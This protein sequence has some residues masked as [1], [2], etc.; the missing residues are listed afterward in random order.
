MGPGF[1]SRGQRLRV[2]RFVLLALLLVGLFVLHGHGRG[3]ET[4]RIV[5]YVG[6][7]GLLFARRAGQSRR[8]GPQGGG[9]G[10]PGGYNQGGYNQGGY[11][12][13]GYNQ[14]GYNQGGYNQ[15]GAVPAAPPVRDDRWPPPAVPA[16]TP[17]MPGSSAPP[18]G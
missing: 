12:Q 3:Y 5:Y 17:D 8:R 2:L 16:P 4:I 9:V 1:G 14:G 10:G 15:G 6:I 13:G 7:I 11:N 18:E